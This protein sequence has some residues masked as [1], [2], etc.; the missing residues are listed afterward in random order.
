MEIPVFH[1]C[2]LLYRAHPIWR[3]QSSI[4]GTVMSSLLLMLR[5]F[6]TWG[7]THHIF[8][9]TLGACNFDMVIEPIL[10]VAIETYGLIFS[11]GTMVT[12]YYNPINMRLLLQKFLY[13]GHHLQLPSLRESVA[14]FCK[15]LF[16]RKTCVVI[17]N[18]ILNPFA[19]DKGGTPGWISSQALRLMQLL[20]P[21]IRA[22]F[23]L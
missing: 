1:N 12:N 19:F 14:D 16:Q 20:V 21:Y 10:P 8:Y 5:L 2:T 22:R 7:T 18:N 9:T 17:P 4:T 11:I 13:D 15:P 6:T 3:Y 23:N